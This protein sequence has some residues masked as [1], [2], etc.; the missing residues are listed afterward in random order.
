M[1][2]KRSKL[3]KISFDLILRN[4]KS[5]SAKVHGDGTILQKE[6]IIIIEYLSKDNLIEFNASKCWL[7]SLEGF[8]IS[9]NV[10]Y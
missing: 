1:K 5:C 9:E 4:A 2:K 6:A 3:L 7:E 8:I 10:L